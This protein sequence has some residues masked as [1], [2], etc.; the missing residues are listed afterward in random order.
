MHVPDP[1][2][3]SRWDLGTKLV[4]GQARA[5]DGGQH[6]VSNRKS[7]YKTNSSQWFRVDPPQR[8]LVTIFA[9][10]AFNH[11]APYAMYGFADSASCPGLRGRILQPIANAL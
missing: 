2:S 11:R 1:F 5:A 3:C 6:R 7:R 8:R 10:C 9:E 4:G